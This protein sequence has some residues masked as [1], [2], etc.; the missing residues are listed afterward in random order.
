MIAHRP[1]EAC[2]PPAKWGLFCG[3]VPVWDPTADSHSSQPVSTGGRDIL[4]TRP[5]PA[6]WPQLPDVEGGQTVPPKGLHPPRPRT[7]CGHEAAGGLRNARVT[8]LQCPYGVGMTLSWPSPQILPPPLDLRPPRT[9]HLLWFFE[10]K[11]LMTSWWPLSLPPA[12]H[13]EGQ[14]VGHLGLPGWVGMGVP[15]GSRPAARAGVPH[16]PEPALSMTW[17]WP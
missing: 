12:C 8:G 17:A 1:A 14:P 5:S 7:A 15:G 9:L 11:H 6:L 4:W 3:F 13:A 10:V 2:L 16:T